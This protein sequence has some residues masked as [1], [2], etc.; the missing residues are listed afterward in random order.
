MVN[1]GELENSGLPAGA[2]VRTA[3]SGGATPPR[4]QGEKKPCFVIRDS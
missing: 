2:V 1:N 3:V 4:T